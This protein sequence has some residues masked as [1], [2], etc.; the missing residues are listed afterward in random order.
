MIFK[1]L[2]VGP[3]GTNCYLFGSEITREIIII[4]PGGDATKIIKMIGELNA[5]PIAV[6]LTH[7]HFDHTLK[8]E[9]LL[10]HFQI[11]LMYNKKEFDSRI[12]TGVKADKWL[13]END[14]ITIGEITLHTLETP[15][16]SPGSL[17]FYTNDVKSF[18]NQKIDGILFSGDLLFQGSIGRSD[19]GGG[20]QS[21]LFQSIKEKIMYNDQLSDNYLVFPGH[22][23]PTTIGEERSTNMF[24]R[25]FL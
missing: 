9:R 8:V 21:Q 19:I 14:T 23:G 24:R 12:Y 2:M 16:H 15:G 11:P 6:L 13:E 25:Y 1:R 3:L 17:C 7:G 10:K 5:T 20:N 4:D 18:N 22:M